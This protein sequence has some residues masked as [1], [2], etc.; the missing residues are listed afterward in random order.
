[1]GWLIAGAVVLAVLAG[2]GWT[3]IQVWS[4]FSLIRSNRSLATSYR[5]RAK[6]LR[7]GQE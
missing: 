1:M 5:D 6:Q 7:G 2:I 3:G 4:Q